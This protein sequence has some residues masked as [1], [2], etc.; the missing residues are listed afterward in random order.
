MAHW[1]KD[2]MVMFRLHTYKMDCP[3][4][5]V[6]KQLQQG[7][8]IRDSH[9]SAHTVA[10]QVWFWLDFAREEDKTEYLE[11]LERSEIATIS[12]WPGPRA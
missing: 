3:P 9:W 5:D 11:W 8:K 2:C 4:R 10:D 1:Q 12:T 7:P 6:A